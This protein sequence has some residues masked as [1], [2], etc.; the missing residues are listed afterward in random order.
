MNMFTAPSPGIIKMH[1]NIS[2]HFEGIE[3][4][5]Y[6]KLLKTMIQNQNN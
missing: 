6:I 5:L 2:Y 3:S 1:I 4:N